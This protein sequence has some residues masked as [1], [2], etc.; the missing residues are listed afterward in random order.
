MRVLVT[1]GAGF[2]GS[3]VVDELQ[4][5]GHEPFALDDLSSG[6]RENLTASVP[7]IEADIRDAAAVAAVF[8]DVQPEA[9]CH[10]AAQV[11]VSRSVR[12]PVFDA[13]VNVMGLLNVLSHCGR[14]GVRRVAFSSSGGALYGDVS[15]PA[16]E[17]HACD[18]ISPY[19]LSKLTG[20]RYLEFF[21]HEHG[22]TGIALRFSN[23]YGPRQD[24][25]GEAGVVAIFSQRLL[26]GE[27]VTINGDGKYVRDYVEVT[28]VAGATAAALEAKLDEPFVAFNVGT[29]RGTDVNQLASVMLPICADVRRGMGERGPIADPQ[30]GP[31]R[32]G[33]LRSSLISPQRLADRLGWEPAVGLDEGLRNTVEWFAAHSPA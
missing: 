4:R 11:S 28:D 26:A 17:T 3:H 21:A 24:P 8:D 2:I 6:H 10:L 30:H 7:L 22:L 16:G 9:V 23:V 29:G 5:R 19:G 33:D 18:P 12:E 15:E 13:D 25:H 14:R 27:A 31:A 20:E 1:G 32:A